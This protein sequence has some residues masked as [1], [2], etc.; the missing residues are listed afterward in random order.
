MSEEYRRTDSLAYATG[1]F[2]ANLEEIYKRWKNNT[3]Q[4]NDICP[5]VIKGIKNSKVNTKDGKDKILGYLSFLG[6]LFQDLEGI[7][8][9]KYDLM[10]EM[11]G[12]D[13]PLKGPTKMMKQCEKEEE[14]T[15]LLKTI[16]HN[17][18]KTISFIEA[19]DTEEGLLSNSLNSFES[20]YKDF[21]ELVTLGN[22][23]SDYI[24]EELEKE[25]KKARKY[26]GF[27]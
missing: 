24:K 23:L 7:T 8:A 4:I 25:H 26:L 6:T 2:Q 1:A 18:S 3:L 15:E 21:N 17:L 22:Q 10:I 16:I 5:R 11:G 14:S 19:G 9:D 27:V 20:A 13:F 12:L